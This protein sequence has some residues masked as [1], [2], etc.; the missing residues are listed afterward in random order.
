MRA[1]SKDVILK[2]FSSN[3]SYSRHIGNSNHFLA[4]KVS[5]LLNLTGPSLNIQTGC[6]TSLVAVIEACK[7]LLAGECEIAIAGGVSIKIPQKTIEYYVK[8]GI[9]SKDGKCRAFDANA[10]GTVSGS[11][12]GVVILKKYVSA[13]KDNETFVA[14][15]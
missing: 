14:K 15:K 6:S 1:A 11:G 10:D 2:N 4:T 13:C 3:D 9:L 12:C 5:Y 8:G 7:S